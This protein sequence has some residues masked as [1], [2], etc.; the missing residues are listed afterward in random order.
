[1]S[2]TGESWVSVESF[3]SFESG[4]NSGGSRVMHMCA[5]NAS[6]SS[7]LLCIACVLLSNDFF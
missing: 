3:N 5:I 7:N 1:M 2:E 4:G 6:I